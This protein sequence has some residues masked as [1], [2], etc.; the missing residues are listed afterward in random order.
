M[1]P[2]A[3]AAL[4]EWLTA[5]RR[6]EMINRRRLLNGEI[7]VTFALDEARPASV[8]GDFN[9]WD[10][11]RN[12]LVPRSTGLRSAAVVACEGAVLRFRYL[13]DAGE[14]FDDP[15]AYAFEDNGQGGTH[16]VVVASIAD[17]ATP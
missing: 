2:F 16:S 5:E 12:P 8:V 7:Q 17:G 14:F 9:D 6:F 4:L 11:Y 1:D 13:A 15:D 10:P 3:D